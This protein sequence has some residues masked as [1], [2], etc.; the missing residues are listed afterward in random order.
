MISMREIIHQIKF[1]NRYGMTEKQLIRHIKGQLLVDSLATEMIT[2]LQRLYEESP[3][4]IKLKLG[5]GWPSTVERNIR[6]AARQ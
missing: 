2:E 5:T 4:D 1:W 6:E 3:D